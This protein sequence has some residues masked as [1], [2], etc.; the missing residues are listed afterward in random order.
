MRRAPSLPRISAALLLAVLATGSILGRPLGAQG[1]Q[2]PRRLT[3]PDSI[4]LELAV[5]LSATGGFGAEP[6]ILVGA[7]PEWVMS[8][9][10]LPS[11]ARV[12]G[13]A[14]IG[15]TVVGVVSVALPPAAA[16]AEAKAAL[17]AHGWT[18]PPAP[19]AMQSGGFRSA[20]A[21]A[22]VA[23]SSTRLTVCGDPQIL[24]AS[25]MTER[26]AATTI[27]YRM[28]T[29]TGYS[30]CRLPERDPQI[31]RV[32]MPTLINPPGAT[33]AQATTECFPGGMGG[34]GSSAFLDTPLTPDALLEHYGKQLADSGWTA[35]DKG[36]FAGRMWTR[37]DSAGEPVELSILVHTL[38]P[39]PKC[40]EAT[41]Q[42]RT[43][44]K[45]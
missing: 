17:L 1:T 34:T 42:V 43:L 6:Q 8:K 40:R 21:A 18:N 3:Q 31:I 33:D 32:S 30:P 28:T 25:A 2:E 26:G 36:S 4:P 38:A 7:M 16:I 12:V 5:A 9:I 45:P 11:S 29:T 44:R 10:S 23:T 37:T 14:F 39:N 22:Q 19:P 13:S 41:M 20:G 15:T 35:G 24:S 27:T